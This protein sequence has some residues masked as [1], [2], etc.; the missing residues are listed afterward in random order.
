M[1]W[2]QALNSKRTQ[3]TLVAIAP[4]VLVV[5]QA[6]ISRQPI[7]FEHC[8]I[9]VGGIGLWCNADSTRPTVKPATSSDFERVQKLLEDLQAKIDRTEVSK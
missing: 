7:P 4:S 8:A 9:I 1:N 5:I 6:L 3:A 2:L